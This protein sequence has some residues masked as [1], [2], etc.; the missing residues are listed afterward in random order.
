MPLRKKNEATPVL[1]KSAICY[2]D[3]A[4]TIC[5]RGILDG[6]Q[7]NPTSNDSIQELIPNKKRKIVGTEY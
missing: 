3:T 6:Y 5:T 2:P 1:N 7:N 4:L